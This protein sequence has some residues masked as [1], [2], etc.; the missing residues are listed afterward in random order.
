MASLLVLAVLAPGDGGLHA[1][2]YL[3]PIYTALVVA[4]IFFLRSDLISIGRF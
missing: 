4:C 2:R 3:V 1:S